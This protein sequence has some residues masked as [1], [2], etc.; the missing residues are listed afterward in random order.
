ML[1]ILNVEFKRAILRWQTWIA[2]VLFVGCIIVG[3]EI[4]RPGELVPF[5]PNVHNPFNAFLYAVGNGARPI[6]PLAFALIVPLVAG[7]TLVWDRR[8]SFYQMSLLRVSYKKYILGKILASSIITAVFALCAQIVG[9]LYC[10]TTFPVPAALSIE[11]GITPTYA[12]ELFIHHPFLY[13]FLII[14]HITLFSMVVVMISVLISNVTK[15][16]YV[17]LCFPWLLFCF[18]QVVFY[19]YDVERYAPVDLVGSYVIGID[20]S[21]WEISVLFTSIWAVLVLTVYG[22]FFARYKGR[23]MK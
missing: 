2:F 7:D 17:V 20:Y 1:H 11:Q 5:D 15:N 6:L 22:I 16:I 21:I 10:I 9:F 8:T 14:A 19:M 12:Q 18:L 3:V 4:F 23:L 13:M